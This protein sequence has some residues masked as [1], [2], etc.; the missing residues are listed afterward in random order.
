VALYVACRMI[1]FRGEDIGDI[2]DESDRF[3]LGGH[4][5]LSVCG[6]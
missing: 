3:C 1:A 5:D 4:E 2:G 6:A